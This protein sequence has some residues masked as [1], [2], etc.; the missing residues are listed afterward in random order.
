MSTKPTP[1]SAP[2]KSSAIQQ[3][4]DILV[5]L[6]EHEKPK[7]VTKARRDFAELDR[8]FA[9]FR[10]GSEFL[11][12][13]LK[14]QVQERE[15]KLSKKREEFDQFAVSPTSGISL[16]STSSTTVCPKALE[17]I[18]SDVLTADKDTIEDWQHKYAVLKEE[19]DSIKETL[20]TQVVQLN[21]L[22]ALKDELNKLKGPRPSQ[23]DR[24][25]ER[26][27]ATVKKIKLVVPPSTA[28]T[29]SSPPKATPSPPRRPLTS[30][31]NPNPKRPH[32]SNA[33]P[34]L[35]TNLPSSSP[36]HLS[37]TSPMYGLILPVS[38]S[39]SSPSGLA[40]TGP[41]SIIPTSAQTITEQNKLSCVPPFTRKTPLPQVSLCQIVAHAMLAPAGPFPLM[42]VDCGIAGLGISLQNAQ[43]CGFVASL[44][45]HAS[46]KMCI[47]H[48][49]YGNF[50][51][52][53]L[54]S[55]SAE[56]RKGSALGIAIS[57]TAFLT[58]VFRFRTQDEVMAKVGHRPGEVGTGGGSKYRLLMGQKALHLLVSFALIYVGVEVT[59]GGS[60]RS[61]PADSPQS[62]VYSA[63]LDRDFHRAGA[64][65]RAVIWVCIIW[66]FGV[67]WIALIWLNRNVGEHF[68]YAI[69]AMA[70]KITVWLVPDQIQNAVAIS[71]VGL[72]LGPMYPIL[73]NHATKILPAWLLTSSMGW[74][75]GFG[76][77]GSALFPFTTGI[78][79]AKYGIGSLQPLAVVMMAIMVA[80]WTI[81]PNG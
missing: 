56:V 73:A 55:L 8:R 51:S 72:L 27:S 57:D 11:Q 31:I 77:A 67:R 34:T 42:V 18:P 62:Q 29:S 28:S 65:W 2:T 59:I 33:P 63:W 80:V 21:Q 43:A 48:A 3:S 47:L 32:L 26:D 53:V 78:L 45:E 71:S 5:C 44:K 14:K 30:S 46:T 49:C 69:V 9:A 35:N 81:V 22:S 74:I 54:R 75:V 10:N 7:V 23:H 58:A 70:L 6:I 25:K 15:E 38:S 76:Q 4:T 61:I 16:A 17:G 13:T 39:F 64:A 68:F 40:L 41:S 52:L 50:H 66:V 20:E 12:T 37:P 19:R 1:P 79:A 36:S 60:C 24:T